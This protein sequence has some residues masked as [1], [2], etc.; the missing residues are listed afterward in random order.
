[1]IYNFS[2]LDSGSD[3][4]NN[5]EIPAYF[6]SVP[7]DERKRA[8]IERLE[9]IRDEKRK[10]LLHWT[11]SKDNHDDEH[12]SQVKELS[13]QIMK[14]SRAAD[15]Q[16]KLA[17]EKE[18][19]LKTLPVNG[20]EEALAKNQS[21][22]DAQS[23][24]IR[25][26]RVQT[27][28]LKTDIQKAKRV[29]AQEGGCKN[30]AQ[31]IRKLEALLE[32]IPRLA[33]DDP[34]EFVPPK[35]PNGGNIDVQALRTEIGELTRENDSL[36]LKLKGLRSRVVTLEKDGLKERVKANL[37]K[38]EKNDEIIEHLR[39]KQRRIKKQEKFRDHIGQQS[40]L[41]VMILGLNAELT[42]RNRELN[43]G[44][45]VSGEAGISREIARLQKR[46]HLLESSMSCV[47]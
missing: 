19:K 11:K 8:E 12:Q 37:V 30:R 10:E 2:G 26:L 23:E 24:R 1:M 41:A 13:K 6:S 17:E 43:Q 15:E 14:L 35:T 27:V 40:R 18:A 33:K 20:N 36:K 29:L 31:K 47:I 3:S 38:S 9:A 39:P 22:A 45:M 4:E 46:L 32:D 25:A 28:S 7:D 42:E 16:R 5:E 21:V 44:E 34:C